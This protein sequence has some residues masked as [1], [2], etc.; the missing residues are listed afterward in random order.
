MDA[1]KF[2]RQKTGQLIQIAVPEQDWSFLPNPLPPSWPFPNELWPL[3]AEAKERLG[4]LN[5]IG[6][7]LPD[8]ELLLKPS[9]RREAIRSS[10]LEG[11]YASPGRAA[12]L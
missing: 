10:S 9:Q 2:G 8:L 11:T 12:A 7:T 1:S 5:G 3:L 6:R 4:T